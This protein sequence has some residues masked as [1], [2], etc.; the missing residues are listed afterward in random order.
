[1]LGAYLGV[2]GA[3]V[4][5]PDLQEVADFIADIHRMVAV[6]ISWLSGRKKISRV[7]LIRNPRG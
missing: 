1:M 5:S 3:A 4:E 6:N 2:D 7:E